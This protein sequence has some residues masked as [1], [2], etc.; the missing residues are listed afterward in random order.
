MGLPLCHISLVKPDWSSIAKSEEKLE[1]LRGKALWPWN[2]ETDTRNWDEGRGKLPT[3]LPGVQTQL[4]SLTIFKNGR[5][6]RRESRPPE[7][8][9]SVRQ[10]GY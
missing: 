10:S 7:E 4:S 6:P 9:R 8:Q 1:V 2:S 3:G 5:A